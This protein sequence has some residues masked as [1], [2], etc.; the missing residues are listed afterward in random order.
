MRTTVVWINRLL[1]TAIVTVV[2]VLG[3][4]VGLGRHYITYA[5]TYQTQIFAEIQQRTGLQLTASR[6]SA[7][8]VHLSPQFTIDNLRVF[9]PLKPTEAVISVDHLVVRVGLF[10][11]LSH[12]GPV[13]SFVEGQGALAVFDEAA[14]GQW[15]LRGFPSRGGSIDPLLNGLLRIHR[16]DLKNS[17]AALHFSGGQQAEIAASS[18]ELHRRGRFRRLDLALR[19]ATG[20]TPLKVVVESRGEPRQ[21]A[22]TA[23]GYAEFTDLDLTPLLPL[24]RGLGVDLTHGRLEG[25]VWLDWLADGTLNVR[26]KI[27]VPTLDLAGIT[28]RDLPP[29]QQLSATFLLRDQAGVWQLWLPQTRALWGG[30]PLVLSALHIKHTLGAPVFSAAL[31]KL[32]LQDVRKLLVAGRVAPAGL[33]QLLDE[34]APTGELHNLHAQLPVAAGDHRQIR[35]RAELSNVQVAPWQGAPGVASHNLPGHTLTKHTGMDGYVDTGI[36]G[37]DVVLDGRDVDVSFPTV[38]HEPIPFTTFRGALQWRRDGDRVLVQSGPM[39]ATSAAGS[40]AIALGL[41]LN[42]HA[43]DVVP[44]QMTLMVGMRNSAARYRNWFIPY[45]LQPSLLAWLD[46]S[47]GEGQLPQGGVIYRGSLRAGDHD[48]RTVQLFLDVRDAELAYQPEWPPLHALDAAVWLDDVNLDV[49]GYRARM[50]DHTALSAIEVSL[51]PLAEGGDWLSVTGH[52]VAQDNDV[53]RLLRESPLKQRFNGVMDSWQWQGESRAELALG[54]PLGGAVAEQTI[55][56][57]GQLGPGKL[58][59]GNLNLAL[60]QVVG[61]MQFHSLAESGK[62]HGLTSSGIVGRLYGRP[63]KIQIATTDAGV[64]QVRVGGRIAMADLRDWLQQP[65]LD[66]T[67]GETAYKVAITINGEASTLQATSNLT[68]VDIDLPPPYAK[69]AATALPLILTMPL[70]VPQRLLL[71]VADWADLRLVWLAPAGGGTGAAHGNLQSGVL[72]LGQTGSTRSEP[73]KLV[74]TGRVPN[75]DFDAWRGV[76]ATYRQR[77]VAPAP[78]SAHAREVTAEVTAEMSTEVTAEVTADS[79][80][81]AEVPPVLPPPLEVTLRDLQLPEVTMFG[82]ILREGKVSGQHSA[83][84]GQPAGWQLLV[85]ADKGRGSVLIPD[86]ADQPLRLVFDE[87]R[88]PAPTPVPAVVPGSV[89]T[90]QNVAKIPDAAESSLL[91]GIDPTQAVAADVQIRQLWR[92]DANWGDLGF[93]LRPIGDGLRLSQLHGELRG[94]RIQPTGNTPAELVWRRRDGIHSTRFKGRLAV[95]NIAD[96]LAQWGFE[97]SIATR[98]GWLD[99]DV[100]WPGAPDTAGLKKL[101]GTA[102]LNM[103][104]GQFLKASGST[105]GALKVVGVFNFANLLRRLQLDFSDLFKGGV[106]FDSIDGKFTLKEGVVATNQSLEINS[107]SSHFRLNG[108]IDFNT[109]LAD[110]E[111]IATLPVAS[112]LPW[113][114]ALAGGLPAAAGLYVASKLFHEQVDH[115]SSAVYEIRG[116]WREPTVKFSSIFDDKLP[117]RSKLAPIEPSPSQAPKDSAPEVPV[118][119]TTAPETTAPETTVPE[120]PAQELQP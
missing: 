7:H 114:A 84:V 37:G 49:H 98:T 77:N 42:V 107:P 11:S 38:Y 1:W 79:A 10:Q 62:K 66:F 108:Q 56:V 8:W 78:E 46:R 41:D 50:F 92:G 109:D 97:R 58:E 30:Q 75:A 54:I 61:P 9:N 76:F 112:N 81:P 52:V 20:G 104:D 21:S 47:I 26:G 12:L 33:V 96:I 89:T 17:R 2:I 95:D 69:T 116:P 36:D 103:A 5:E 35:L 13:F 88:L 118:P 90:P 44:P 70:Q 80:A 24:V 14:L 15:Q 22:F 23:H 83:A 91:S 68:G 85:Q 119:E 53:L 102:A 64:T 120:V 45:T 19:V 74:V 106:S 86:A 99:A 6:L 82:Q 16:A 110:M 29:V 43:G 3:A 111:L 40:A 31:P 117:E 4:L 60:D 32:V 25:S 48:H 94:I 71:S 115:F 72:R 67:R 93:R 87:L 39:A 28:G 57:D 113:L 18:V 65:L 105:S 100:S 59:L 101:D 51:R 34:L 73:G 27:A 55:D 63:A